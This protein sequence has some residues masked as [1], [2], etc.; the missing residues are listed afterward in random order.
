M[1]ELP[2]VETTR[3]GIAPHILGQRVAG[4][5]VRE[6]RLRYPVPAN[7]GSL[8]CGRSVAAVQRRGK[9]LWLDCRTGY[10]IVHLGMS[11]SLCIVPAS[12][13]A[14]RH[15]HVD[16]QFR[17]GAS[18]RLHD[19]RRFSVLLWTRSDPLRHALLKDIGVEPLDGGLD[20]DYLYARSRGRRVAV[21]QFIMDGRIVAGVGNIYA[22]EALHLAAISP[23]RPAGRVSRARYQRL[24][25]AI[26]T[27]L[28]E[29]IDH[30]GT[31]LRDFYHGDG[32][33]GY[34]QQQL[35]VYQ[36]PDAPCRRCGRLI[37][38]LR[39]GQRSSFYCT[40]CQR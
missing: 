38:M 2:E 15:D 26:K 35:R 32:R 22:N 19:P 7:L 36:R 9:Y 28:G 30:G 6:P 34:F 14:R 13:P 8:L 17:H 37:R 31:T 3:R 29:A 25:E 27:V 23:L 21:K 20:G 33:P 39:V 18:L 12:T 4:V 16:I 1:P 10:L 11:G 5:I 40:G 24:G